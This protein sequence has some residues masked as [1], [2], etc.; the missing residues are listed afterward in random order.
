ML[1]Q[2][3]IRIK[4]DGGT[5]APEQIDEFIAGVTSNKVTEGQV[6]AL[7]MAVL[8]RGMSL[9]ERVALTKAMSH[10]GRIMEWK[11]LGLNGP[12]LDKHSTGGV[13]DKTSLVLGPLVAACGGYVP[14]ISGRGLGHTGGTLDKFDS[15]PGY[16]TQPDNDLFRK[17]V[18][19]AG[20][21]IIGQT[22]DLAPA[23]K[24]IYAIR[25]TTGTVES[26]DLI[27]AS[28][29]AKKL[30][31]GLD[32]LVMDVKFGTGAF[33]QDYVK[34][35]A[36]AESIATVAT[37]AG[38]KT[39]ALLTDMNQV[40]GRTAGNAVEMVECIE[41]L[42]GS[43]PEARLAEVTY[44]L[45][46]ELLVL[47]GLAKDRTEG[48]KKCE[49]AIASGAAAEKFAQM[50]A[51][52]GG[53]ADILEKYETYLP[54]ARVQLAVTPPQAGVVT[55][56]DVRAIGI[57]VVELGGGRAAPGDAIDH[58]VGLTH[59]AQIGEKV[60]SDQPIAIVH[61]Q[62]EASAKATAAKILAH[63]QVEADYKVAQ[64]EPIVK[65]QVMAE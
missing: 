23:D 43:K 22:P 57:A 17:V 49:A 5:L 56:M 16:K 24:R 10:S 11:S 8:L 12:V 32:C 14:M 6:A 46:A 25:D 64:P 20:C 7:C 15:I 42:K 58:A 38:V 39:T 41:W 35:K 37:G 55:G 1:P 53:P 28:I 51:G 27:T 30:A 52:L 62:D 29:L 18:R 2:E 26:L 4:R 54:K 36:L 21:A 48:I 9:P 45:T 59:F 34:A 63:V 65:E 60:G 61:A 13:G 19:E 47:G 40:L 3:I 50:V 33:M 44:A 31:A